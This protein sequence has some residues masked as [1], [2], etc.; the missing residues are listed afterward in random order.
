M[1]F[2]RP[3]AW[4]CALLLVA[5]CAGA[6]E[7]EKPKPRKRLKLDVE[8]HVEKVLKRDDDRLRFE[9]QVEVVA[10]TPDE[11]LARFVEGADLDCEP[12]GVGAPTELEMR[13]VR[14]GPAPY[15]DVLALANAALKKLKSR[16][17]EK[18]FLYRVTSAGRVRYVVRESEAPKGWQ[19]GP[20]GTVTEL[21]AGYPDRNSAT[22]AWRRLER[23]VNKPAPDASPPPPF[24]ASNCK[25][26]R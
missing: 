7:P 17:R 8:R 21:V 15:F 24:L 16:G 9:T 11:L 23:G 4:A 14:P 20:G 10:K 12:A 25:P 6:A 22:E 18:F 13:E 5:G 1:G 19:I 2:P 3:G 26:G